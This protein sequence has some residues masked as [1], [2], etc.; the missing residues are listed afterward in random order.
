MRGFGNLRKVVACVMENKLVVQILRR[1]GLLVY[2][3]RFC[4]AE[5][6]NSLSEYGIINHGKNC[7][8]YCTKGSA[9]ETLS[10]LINVITESKGYECSNECIL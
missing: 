6:V 10:T 9:N 3:M 8:A 4:K 1:K 7:L 5:K 2:E